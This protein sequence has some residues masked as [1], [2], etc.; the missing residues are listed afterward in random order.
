[1][2]G[3]KVRQQSLA[4]NPHQ[5]K[6]MFSVAALRA[7]GVAATVLGLSGCLSTSKV[8]Y[9]HLFRENIQISRVCEGLSMFRFECGHFPPDGQLSLLGK[10][11]AGA[12]FALLPESEWRGGRII[13]VW[14]K[15]LSYTNRGSVCTVTSAGADGIFGTADDFILQVAPRFENARIRFP[16][17]RRFTAASSLKR[18]YYELYERSLPPRDRASVAKLKLEHENAERNAVYWDRLGTD[19]NGTQ[20]RR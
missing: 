19:W 1:M 11:T 4:H 15:E 7:S 17:E 6:A 18:R 2:A 9:R 13:D 10:R 14:G 3:P 12:P 8:P 5:E 20:I 16:N